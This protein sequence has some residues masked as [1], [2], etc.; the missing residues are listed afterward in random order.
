MPRSAFPIPHII[1]RT[2]LRSLSLAGQLLAL[3][4]RRH[5]TR[6]VLRDLTRDE[7]VDVGLTEDQRAA[8]CAKWFWEA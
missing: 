5:R 4:A 2:S 3:W 1:V 6:L 7:L 8:E